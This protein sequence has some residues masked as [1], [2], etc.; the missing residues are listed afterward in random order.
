MSSPLT[1]VGVFAFTDIEGSSE[2]SEQYGVAFEQSRTEHFQ[3]LRAPLAAFEGQEVSTAGDSLF[4]VFATASQAVGWAVE[5]QCRLLKHAWPDGMV[6]RV[7]IGLHVGEG[8]LTENAGRLDYFGPAVHRAA[9]IM[10]AGHGGQI[11]VS[12]GVR[13]VTL[14]W[15]YL[16]LGEH[17]LKGVGLENL[18]QVLHPELPSTFPP[19]QTLS[20]H[21]HN[22]PPSETAFIGRARELDQLQQLL[23]HEETRRLIT[24]TGMGGV[25][26]TRIARQAAELCVDSFPGGIFWVPLDD[27]RTGEGLLRRLA[28]LLKLPL[29]SDRSLVEQIGHA[30]NQ[31]GRSLL[32]LDNLEQIEKVE[33]VVR[34]LLTAA[35]KALLLL[36]TRRKLNL[37]AETVFEIRPMPQ[38]DATQLFVDRARASRAD[39]A[40][41]EENKGDVAELCRSLEGV[42]LALEL[43]AAR[44]ASLTPRQVLSRLDERF[45]LLQRRAPDLPER[46]RAL[47]AAIDWSYD[48]LTDDDKVLFGQLAV[49]VGPF[50]LEEAEAVCEVFDVFEGVLAL[51]ENSLLSSETDTQTQEARFLM[52][53]SLRTYAAERLAENPEEERAV[54][55]R[56]AHYFLQRAEKK[57]TLLRTAQEADALRRLE[58][59]AGNLRGSLSW[60]LSTP[61]PGLSAKLALALAMPLQRHGFFAEAATVLDQVLKQTRQQAD[62]VWERA[63]LHL[64]LKETVL[65]RTLAEEARAHYAAQGDQRAVGRAENLIG[66]AYLGDSVWNEARTAFECAEQVLR[67]ANDPLERAIVQNNLALVELGDPAGDRVLAVRLLT[68]SL[69]VRQRHG[70]QRGVAVTLNNL[71]E[72]AFYRSDWQEA[73]RCYEEALQREVALDHV[74]GIARALNNLGEVAEQQGQAEV[75]LLLYAAALQL[76]TMLRHDYAAYTE[77]LLHDLAQRTQADLDLLRTQMAGK[78]PAEL[79]ALASA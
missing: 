43:A 25:G 19:L 31:Q 18:W 64:D 49:F 34:D 15:N 12:Q 67:Q 4:V 14:A 32:L 51:R 55:Q 79:A 23:L 66:Q 42:P 74:F 63:G 10:S 13:E 75:A 61:D 36:T 56:H 17:R 38:N 62:L 50:G 47:R 28:D 5:V 22:L 76:F 68:E 72:L 33:M 16:N 52:L 21:R 48:L 59:L 30:F 37:R 53:E 77:G 26:K 1:G 2:L 60:A 54:R 29:Q 8:F 73:R 7:R 6:V 58:L 70:D 11:V 44:I 57:L 78:T 24:L 3:L 39:F 65:A 9:R 41:T 27:I 46:Q 20:A 45:R 35:S 40:L 69:A 71:G